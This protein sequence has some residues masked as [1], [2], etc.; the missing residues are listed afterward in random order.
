M[1]RNKIRLAVVVFVAMVLGFKLA[2]QR[3]QG[4]A[5]DAR[6]QPSQAVVDDR[7]LRPLF[8]LPGVDGET[9]AIS[10]WDGKVLVINF[11]AT[12]C[13]PCRKEIPEFVALQNAYGEA[14]VQFIGVAVDTLENVI[15]YAEEF[16][17]NY[18]LLVGDEAAIAAGFAY[19]NKIG[20]LPYTAI[21]DRDGRVVLRHQGVLSHDQAVAVL[22][23]LL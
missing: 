8:S 12:W 7:E 21:V 15:A 11:W 18:P 16:G 17:I 2:D 6:V 3:A 14:G 13:A 1:A 22:E 5:G 10:E 19:G 9:H 23:A 20:G 4:P